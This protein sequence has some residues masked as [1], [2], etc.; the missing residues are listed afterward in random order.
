MVPAVRR[1][2]SA[3]GQLAEETRWHELFRQH[4]GTHTDYDESGQRQL[5]AL[6]PRE[7]WAEFYDAYQKRTPWDLSGNEVL[8][9]FEL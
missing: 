3:S 1:R 4:V 9:W 2:A 6:Q 7:R 8:G 5:G